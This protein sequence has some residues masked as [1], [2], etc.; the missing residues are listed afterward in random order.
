MWG[1]LI[2]AGAS[3]LGNWLGSEK[4]SDAASEAAARQMQMLQNAQNYMNQAFPVYMQG[5]RSNIDNIAGTRT[6]AAM[7]DPVN[8]EQSQR[9][10][11]QGNLNNLD[12]INQLVQGTNRGTLANDI[13]RANAFS[14]GAMDTIASLGS[15]ASRLSQGQL[16]FDAIEDIISDSS[17]R[18][19]ALG[20]PGGNSPATLRDLGLNSLNAY[21]QG[22]NLLNQSLQA[23]EQISP[24]SRQMAAG[25]Y[26]I[27]PGQQLQTDLQQA[28]LSQQSRQNA[29][30]LNSAPDPGAAMIAQL[31]LQNIMNQSSIMAGGAQL[32]QPDMTPYASIY[33]QMGN[34]ISNAL[35]GAFGGGGN[36]YSQGFSSGFGNNSGFNANA[37]NA[38]ALNYN[39]NLSAGTPPKA[40]VV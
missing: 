36:T 17:S 4:Q 15:A 31:H 18:A 33:G 10:G 37:Y 16:P 2:G 26:M 1:A 27:T 19:G 23:A 21:Q 35:T 24:I 5:L 25:Q 29:N 28:Q 8:V 9:T 22:A 30:N 32:V 13:E 3:L 12:V 34:T 7:Y 38:G 14:P 20:T 39:Q 6:R 11:V 40:Y